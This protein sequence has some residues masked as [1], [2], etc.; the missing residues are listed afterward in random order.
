MPSR[1]NDNQRA[2]LATFAVALLVAALFYIP[3]RIESTGD[4]KWAPFYRNPVVERSTLIEESIET[5]FVRVKGQPVL[6]LYL[7]QL[8]AI[9]ATGAAVYRRFGDR[10]A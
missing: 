2:V 8:F 4:L 1:P 3:W 6:G 7:L 10:E 9:G 5:E